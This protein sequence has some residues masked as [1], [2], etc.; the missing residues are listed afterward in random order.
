MNRYDPPLTLRQRWEHMHYAKEERKLRPL[1]KWIDFY[2]YIWSYG[3]LDFRGKTIID[4]GA[5]IGSTALY[6]LR[7]GA[8][9]V[10]L[11][12]NDKAYNKIYEK[13]K[14]SDGYPQLRNTALLQPHELTT[15]ADILKMDCE[16]CEQQ[17]L[18]DEL[19]KKFGQFAVALHRPQLDSYQ[20]GQ[21]KK[22]LEKHGGRYF[23]NI[24]KQEF[25]WLKEKR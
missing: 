5:D 21:K 23:G 12:E 6:F 11:L 24:N 15:R 9:F 19:L 8:S 16:G 22:L 20:F 18:T 2:D 17:L 4:I 3:K 10:Y 25:L 14:A 1:C 13:L 7:K